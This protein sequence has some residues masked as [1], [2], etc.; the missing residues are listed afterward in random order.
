MK[1]KACKKCKIIFEGNTC[2]ICKGNQ[3]SETWKGRIV[4][5]DENSEIGKKL[6]L[7]GKGNFA[8]RVG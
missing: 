4:I 7:K 3:L 8:V 5:L 1:E 6:N 2:P